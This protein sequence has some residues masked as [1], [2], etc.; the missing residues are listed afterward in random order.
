VGRDE[1]PS[2]IIVVMVVMVVPWLAVE[3]ALAVVGAVSVVTVGTVDDDIVVVAVVVPVDVD[4]AAPVEVPAVVLGGRGSRRQDQ[5]DG[6]Q[7]WNA[8]S[9]GSFLKGL[10]RQIARMDLNGA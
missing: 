8:N 1:D 7:G 4:V 2:S 10:C 9:H 5:G 6:N 3:P